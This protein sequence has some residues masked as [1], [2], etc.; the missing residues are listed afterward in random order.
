MKVVC[1]SEK[2][3]HG[4]DYPNVPDPKVGEEVTVIEETSFLGV[5]C[6]L[7]AE[8]TCPD[9]KSEWLYDQRNFATLNN[10]LDETALV[11]EEWEEKY[12]VP[13]NSNVCG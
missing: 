2:N 11:N 3:Y 8:Y 7:L 9:P 4:H 5:A 6:Y 10:D 12:C 1:I 13:V